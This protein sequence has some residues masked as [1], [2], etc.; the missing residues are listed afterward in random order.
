MRALVL[1]VT[2]LA[3]ARPGRADS[4]GVV[5]SGEPTK[6]SSLAAQLRA[7]LERNHHA[8][9]ATPLDGE[10]R[11]TM[12]NCFVIEDVA[13]AKITFEKRSSA[14]SL[15]FARVELGTGHDLVVTAY[16][17]VKGR[18][19]IAEKRSCKH[20]D[21]VALARTVDELMTALVREGNDNKGSLE[22]HSKPE[23]ARV[24]VDGVEI[25]VTPVTRDV[26]AGSHTIELKRGTDTVGTKIVKIEPGATASVSLRVA[27]GGAVHAEPEPAAR[28]QLLPAITIGVG[29]VAIAGAGVYF[30]YGH[31]GGPDAPVVYPHATRDGAVLGVVGL[32]ALVAGGLWWRHNAASSGPIAAVGSGGAMVGW[33]GGF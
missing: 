13:C 2:L 31:K 8:V 28:S 20:C 17:M 1:I 14:S 19:V 24:M 10:A 22:I 21:D 9:T 29:V 15:V 25:G 30:Y 26:A 32:A 33:A 3:G 11:K 4:V 27:E 23:G 6:Q 16:W 5:V 7:W 12:L 18:D